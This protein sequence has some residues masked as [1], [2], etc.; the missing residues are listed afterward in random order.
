MQTGR[1]VVYRQFNLN[2][3]AATFELTEVPVPNQIGSREVLVR[4]KAAMVHPCDI[5]CAQG[6]VNGVV[7]P[8]VGGLEAL[9]VVERVG[10]DLKGQFV[11][12]QRV[13]V[14]GTHMFGI[15]NKWHG[16][17][18]DYTVCPPEALVVV[19]DGVPDEAA[20]QL[21]VNVLTPFA[22]VKEM[23]LGKGDVLLQTAAGSVLGQVMIQLGKAFGFTTINLVR[24]EETARH[25]KDTH[26]IDTVFVFDG[27]EDSAE[28]TRLDI[29]QRLGGKPIRF[30][31][32]AVSGQTGRLCLDLLGPDGLVYF[33]GILSGDL[34]V[35]V[36]IVAD[37]CMNNNTLKGW[38]IQ[39]TWLRKTPDEVKRGYIDELWQLMAEGQVVL[40]KIGQVFP[41]EQFKEAVMASTE[42][43]KSGKVML[44]CA[45][46]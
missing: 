43:G 38:S 21:F 27:S 46:D 40:P 6:L 13:H 36:D 24:R 34:K 31:I 22:M 5:C 19:P 18:R 41:L 23:G 42:M 35:P 16:V 45:P 32:E 14:A 11:P 44:A 7:L 15:W 33:Y 30:A 4:I 17:W 20:A 25:L 29:R 1:E 12:G 26:G 8:A 39:E 2:N 28:A 3:P 9:G 10:S 37:L